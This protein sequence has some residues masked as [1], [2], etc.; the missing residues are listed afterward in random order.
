MKGG[1]TQAMKKSDK[2][3]EKQFTIQT[4]DQEPSLAQHLK[5]SKNRNPAL[6]IVAGIDMG[7]FMLLDRPLVLLGR[8][9]E[10]TFMIRDDG[11]SRRHAE[12]HHDEDGGYTIR[13]LDSTNGLFVN[14]IRVA[15]H[16]L[17]DGD[18]VLL[19]RNSVLQYLRLDPVDIQFHHKMHSSTVRDSLT[20][21]FNRKYFDER[22]T[23]ELSYAHRHETPVSLLMADL[24]HFK[25]V[26]DKW[27][28]QA[29]DHVLRI[30][31]QTIQ[32]FL[33]SEDVLAR[34]GGEE[35]AIIARNTD[36]PSG[37]DLGE[38]LRREVEA[39]KVFTTDKKAIKLS[40]SIGV[41]A[42]DGLNHIEPAELIS[43]A[44]NNLYQAKQKGRNRVESGQ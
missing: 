28:H 22:L 25:Q 5:D 9:P 40:I 4:F 1:I 42:C 31:A 15:S 10:C 23:Y 27:G 6:V 41:A 34:Y 12:L 26:N 3:K 32:S 24:D 14:G 38:R 8:D 18:K 20:G 17:V 33:R 37:A 19:G 43:R 21:I 35:F 13:D 11:I 30:T 29:G 39:T 36:L 44:D 7:S 16:K 2:N